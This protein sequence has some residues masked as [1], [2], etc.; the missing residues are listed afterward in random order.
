MMNSWAYS[1][2]ILQ[3]NIVF[4]FASINIKKQKQTNKT[5]WN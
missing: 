2:N 4:P 1:G 5:N 3:R